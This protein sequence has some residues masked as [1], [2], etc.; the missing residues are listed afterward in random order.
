MSHQW[1]GIGIEKMGHIFG[2]K[3]FVHKLALDDLIVDRADVVHALKVG[4]SCRKME[5]LTLL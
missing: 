2:K 4:L 5:V 3:R 1:L